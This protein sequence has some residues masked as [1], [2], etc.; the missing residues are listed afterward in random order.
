[1]SLIF[2]EI[3]LAFH[4]TPWPV[5]IPLLYALKELYMS[6]LWSGNLHLY[7]LVG[8]PAFGESTVRESAFIYLLVN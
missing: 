6:M 5:N 2:W 7:A 8:V 1:M 4:F 3:A